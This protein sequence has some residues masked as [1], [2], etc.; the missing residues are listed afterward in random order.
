MD[1]PST[2]RCCFCNKSYRSLGNHYKGCPGRNGADYQHLLA[3]GTLAD[4]SRSKPDRQ[5]CPKCGK[6]FIRLETHLRRSASCKNVPLPEDLCR[7]SSRAP[8]SS[9]FPPNPAPAHN[10]VPPTLL[11]RAKLPTTPE[12]WAELDHFIQVN[13]TP[14]VMHQEDVNVMQHVIT[15]DLYS[16]LV[17]KFG[18]TPANQRHQRQQRDNVPAATRNAMREVI[19]E[20]KCIK[21]ELRQL[22]RCGSSSEEIKLVAEKFHLVIRRHSKL[23]KE[24]KRL[25][26]KASAKQSRREC[27]R[28][29]HKFARKVLEDENYTST[30]P[31]FSKQRAEEYFSRVYSTTPR[32]FNRPEWMPACPSPTTP[33]CTDPFTEEELKTVISGLKSSSAPSP[34]DQIPYSVFKKCPSLL[35]AMLHLLNC[36][37]TTHAVPTAWKVGIVH[38]LGKKKATD[39]PSDPSNFRPIALTSCVSKVFTSLVK[40]RW[41]AYMVNNSFLN[42]ATQKAFVDGVPGCSEHHL[43][44][45][46]IL[47]EAQTRRKSV[48]V[49]W[50]DLANAFGS[51]HHDLIT[52]SLAHYHAPQQMIELV[53]E[54][55]SGLSAV[56]STKSWTTAPIHLQLGVYQ[57]DPLSVAI[58]NT[59]MNTLVDSITQ[60][61]SYLG[62]KLNSV[63]SAIN[64]LQYADDTTLIGDGPA[65]CQ[66]LLDL[67]ES[68]LSWSG[69]RANVPK[70]VSVAIRASSGKAYNPNLKLGNECIPYLG[71]TT[72]H[73]LGAPVAI[74]ATSV[75]TR[76]HLIGKLFTMLQKVD[77]V[78]ITRQQKLKLF[79][80]AICP[81]LTWDLAT[82]DLPISWLQNHLQPA[83]TRFLKRWSGLARSADP[84]RLFLPK[85]NGG[86]ELPHLVT[87]YKKIHAA[88]AGSHM[89]SGD[90]AVRAIAT[91]N[92]LHE[93]QLQRALF[94]PHQEV[95]GVMKEDPSAPKKRVIARVKAAIQSEDTA[96]RLAHTTSLPV[97]GLTVREFEGRAALN[98]TTA[99]STLPEWCFKFA[100]NSVTDTLPHNS[101][102]CRWKKLPSPQCQL[103]GGYQSLAHILNSC[104]K[105]LDLRRYTTRHNSV[106]KTIVYFIRSH[107][108][109]GMR[110][111]ADLPEEEY[112]FPQDVA[113]TDLRPDIVIWD[114]QVIHIIEL[115]VPF[116][117]NAVDAAERKTLHYQ[118]LRESCALRRRSSIITLEVGSRGFL[119]AEGFQKLYS[120]LCT[121]S[122][123]R[124]KFEVEVIRE[125]IASSYDIWCKRNWCA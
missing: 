67:T 33:M 70:C 69:M 82:S 34:A 62:Y 84:N 117:T 23:V 20:K 55:Y 104:P 111:T 90:S 81:R 18:V 103:C 87:M 30:Q 2:N 9:E 102:L 32:T 116:E 89:Y 114:S 68:W 49:S 19:E 80:V 3:Q 40:K 52:F 66:R 86:L 105:A 22:R 41:L 15:N 107:L 64:L 93:S 59:V 24:V 79:K 43:K 113:S 38:L 53:S 76:E 26:A 25:N 12:Q 37:W 28:D 6:R 115:T 74:H 101:N 98:W 88:K 120:L 1:Q 14:V 106:L 73:F 112:N 60:H 72:F 8:S 125:V 92:T 123:S 7:T 65:S 47:R 50:L 95:V 4:K 54:L 108:P 44:L 56:V 39:N 77:A 10:P 118:D 29:I 36:C 57:G 99:I 110:V 122:K 100:L 71:D 21:K 85:A 46:S 16:Y 109:D 11:L 121:K 31:S 83:A 119:C 17:S 42:T 94:R 75:Q 63:S 78:P 61:C 27:H 45:L 124:Q 48:C 97:Q 91:Q 96:A 58:F 5:T 13:I 35:P 51:V